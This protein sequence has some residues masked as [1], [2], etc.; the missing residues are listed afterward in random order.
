MARIAEQM[1]R[2]SLMAAAHLLPTPSTR[3]PSISSGR[4][5]FMVAAI[6][7]IR[8]SALRSARIKGTAGGSSRGRK[9]RLG[10]PRG[11]KER[12]RRGCGMH[13][14]GC[15]MRSDELV[16]GIWEIL[17]AGSKSEHL[18]HASGWTEEILYPCADLGSNFPCAG[19][20]AAI[21]GG[22]CGRGEEEAGGSRGVC[23]EAAGCAAGAAAACGLGRTCAMQV[24]GRQHY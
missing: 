10:D 4:S 7:G 1:G 8:S 5:A 3:A 13:A 24:V 2:T 6:K 16:C 11:W 18:C 23:R 20:A 14:W 21:G 17:S 19:A 12:L 15:G 22:C 9:E